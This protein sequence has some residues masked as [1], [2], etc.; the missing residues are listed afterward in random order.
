M[1]VDLSKP[2][3][4]GG[5]DRGRPDDLLLS[6]SP[7]EYG[8]GETIDASEGGCM[9]GDDGPEEDPPFQTPTKHR[10]QPEVKSIIRFGKLFRTLPTSAYS[11]LLPYQIPQVDEVLATIFPPDR[12]D[13]LP[14]LIIDATA[15]IGGDAIHF[16][17]VYPE[18]NIVA[19]DNDDRAIECLRHNI[20]NFSIPTRFEVVHEDS[21]EWIRRNDRKAD[22]YYFDPPWGGPNYSSRTEVHLFLG[23]R[24]IVD[25]VN[26]ILERGLARKIL[27][28]TPR[29]FAYPSF[30]TAVKGTTRLFFIRKTQQQRGT[31]AYGLILISK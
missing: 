1:E 15:H 6:S 5:D 28:K 18:A 11:S 29:N 13:E 25:I 24:P 20:E 9:A 26:Y 22:L 16:A 23:E 3:D 21:S 31:V 10:R 4:G 17:S 14:R 8:V 30:K 7:D 27:L 12:H 19:I 2:I